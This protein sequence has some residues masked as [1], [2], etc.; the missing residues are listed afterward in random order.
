MTDQIVSFVA[1]ELIAE[2]KSQTGFDDFGEPP[3]REGLEVLLQTY[4]LNV[5][6]PEGRQRCRDRLVMPVS[7]T[8]LT[9]PTN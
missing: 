3:Y 8:H 2:A 1:D 7:Y 6:D 9:L 5:K 4:D